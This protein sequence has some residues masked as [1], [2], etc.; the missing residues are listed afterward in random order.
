MA[1]KRTVELQIIVDDKGTTKKLK[2]DADQLEN[3]LAKTG[4]QQKNFRKQR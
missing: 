2:V 4:K 3:A 1:A